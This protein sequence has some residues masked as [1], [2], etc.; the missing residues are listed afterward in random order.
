M[1]DRISA[2]LDPKPDQSFTKGADFARWLESLSQQCGNKDLVLIFDEGDALANLPDDLRTEFLGE[3]RTQ[4]TNRVMSEKHGSPVKVQ[5]AR[6]A[7]SLV[8]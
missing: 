4:K 3:L 8:N 2:G 7:A 6:P 1:W 5:L